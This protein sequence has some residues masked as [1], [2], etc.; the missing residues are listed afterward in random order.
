MA[1]ASF[2]KTF[3][4]TSVVNLFMFGQVLNIGTI[5]RFIVD[6]C[7]FFSSLFFFFPCFV[8]YYYVVIFS[9]VTNKNQPG[10]SSNQF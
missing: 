4:A 7:V 5:D 3:M 6:G 9:Y 1:V 10:V 8:S 2:L